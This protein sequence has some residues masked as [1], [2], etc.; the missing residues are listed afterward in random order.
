M[1]NSLGGI[2]N[3][4]NARDNDR[5]FRYIHYNTL[6]KNKYI[7]ERIAALPRRSPSCHYHFLSWLTAPI[8]EIHEIL[9][10]VTQI[11]IPDVTPGVPIIVELPSQHVNIFRFRIIP[12]P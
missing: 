9:I 7:D 8:G 6:V 10:V 2:V 5:I 12:I 3:P 11:H 4:Q 1:Q